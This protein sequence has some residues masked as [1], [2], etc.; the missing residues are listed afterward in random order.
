MTAVDQFLT[1][2]VNASIVTPNELV[3]IN[4][5][6][7]QLDS[8]PNTSDE[9]INIVNGIMNFHGY[10]I[11]VQP[12]ESIIWLVG[13]NPSPIQISPHSIEKI[14]KIVVSVEEPQKP[15][16]SEPTSST[17]D[18]AISMSLLEDAEF[19]EA[20]KVAELAELDELAKILQ[21]V[22]EVDKAED[23]KFARIAKVA[24]PTSST[25]VPAG[26]VRTRRG[27]CTF[28]QLTR[29]R[30][31]RSD[32]SLN[33]PGP[34]SEAGSSD[35][36][37]RSIPF[38]ITG[39]SDCN[40]Y[41]DCQ[42]INQGSDLTDRQSRPYRYPRPYTGAHQSH[43]EEY[44]DDENNYRTQFGSYSFKRRNDGTHFSPPSY[45]KTPDHIVHQQV[46]ASS[47]F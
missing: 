44:D 8:D 7:A 14:D 29:N 20:S 3:I 47:Y 19:A 28:G 27:N 30:V 32:T 24:I 42:V 26:D 33:S 45:P 9:D 21:V 5:R 1:Q 25:L 15:Y 18:I 16:F 31:N 10:T 40:V 17:N 43:Q 35:F 12:N 4:Q 23:T 37:I 46:D 41:I 34:S 38:T 36:G 13:S 11:T 2:L 39:S 6:Y 22:D